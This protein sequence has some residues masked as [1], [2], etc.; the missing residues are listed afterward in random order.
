MKWLKHTILNS[1][2]TDRQQTACEL[3]KRRELE[4][5]AGGKYVRCNDG[6]RWVRRSGQWYRERVF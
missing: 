6:T 2:P 5:R 3:L 1:N 4:R